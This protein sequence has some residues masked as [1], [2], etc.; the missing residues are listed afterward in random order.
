MEKRL[1]TNCGKLPEVKFNKGAELDKQIYKEGEPTWGCKYGVLDVEDVKKFIIVIKEDFELFK[2][3]QF[4]I[5]VGMSPKFNIFLEQ[6]N[7]RAGDLL[8]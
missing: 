2:L 7:K 6:I 5:G 1:T 8:L 4:G 3:Q